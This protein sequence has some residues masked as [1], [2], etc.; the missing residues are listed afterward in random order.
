MLRVLTALALL[1]QRVRH[2]QLVC[3]PL[4]LLQRQLARAHSVQQVPMALVLAFLQQAIAQTV[5]L[6]IFRVHWVQQQQLPAHS[7]AQEHTLPKG[8]NTAVVPQ[9]LQHVMPGRPPHMWMEA[10]GRLW[11]QGHWMARPVPSHTP[12]LPVQTKIHGGA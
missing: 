11:P 4:P 8:W 7:V 12:L 5:A 2:V 1:S 3:I 6:A 9:A 10:L